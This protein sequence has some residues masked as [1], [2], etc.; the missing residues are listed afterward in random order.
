MWITCG[1]DFA[2]NTATPYPQPA[3]RLEHSGT[4]PICRPLPDRLLPQP[5]RRC[6]ARPPRLRIVSG[7]PCCGRADA[8]NEWV[9]ASGADARRLAYARSR[10]PLQT[11]QRAHGQE[12]GPVVRQVEW[13][14]AASSC[15]CPATCRDRV[16]NFRRRGERHMC[17]GDTT[18]WLSPLLARTR[19][20]GSYLIIL[21]FLE[22]CYCCRGR[23]ILW[24]SG[25]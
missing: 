3:R 24:T 5:V 6:R 2:L 23:P 16:G 19:A 14:A 18:W 12:Q 13:T 4:E 25:Y 22:D 21:Y 11:A 15:G 8:G 20:A 17:P 7:R 9:L 10:F 1:A